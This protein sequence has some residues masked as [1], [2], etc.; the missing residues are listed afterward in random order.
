MTSGM[1][2]GIIAAAPCKQIHSEKAIKVVNPGGMKGSGDRLTWM[3]MVS[4]T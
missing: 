2:A 3:A 1:S 4:P